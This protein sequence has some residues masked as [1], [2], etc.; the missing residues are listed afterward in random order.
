MD[1]A[2]KERKYIFNFCKL[3]MFLM[4]LKSVV[5]NLFGTSDWFRQRQFFHAPEV[6]GNGFTRIH[7]L[8]PSFVLLLLHLH[9]I[10]SGIRSQ[11]LETLA[12]NSTGYLNTE[13]VEWKICI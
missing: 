8:C 3:I 4:H 6:K 10:S 1:N 12:L 5:P 7:I 11:R 9:L 13:I 2:A